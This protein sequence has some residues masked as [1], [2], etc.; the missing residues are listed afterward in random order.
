MKELMRSPKGKAIMNSPKGKL[1]K[2][3]LKNF[4]TPQHLNHYR[5][6]GISPG[7]LSP[8]DS[9][10]LSATP[11]KPN[12]KSA[13]KVSRRKLS[14][15]ASGKEDI[16]QYGKSSTKSRSSKP[17]QKF[18]EILP[19]GSYPMLNV[20]VPQDS[21]MVLAPLELASDWPSKERLKYARDFFKRTLEKAVIESR[22]KQEQLLEPKE[23]VKPK[24]E[25]KKK[26]V[27]FLDEDVK[28]PELKHALE[29]PSI[30][31]G[32]R[33]KRNR[34]PSIK[35]RESADLEKELTT[36]AAPFY[37][38]YE[39]EELE[40]D[41]DEDYGA[42]IWKSYVPFTGYKEAKKRRNSTDLF[43]GH[44]KRKKNLLLGVH[45]V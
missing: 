9:N 43:K 18:Q 37:P 3:R 8:S 19:K 15:V 21:E 17:V 31:T 29:K 45:I 40:D 23:E 12:A 16:V 10:I 28:Y 32:K 2:D 7:I 5:Q 22:I 39:D 13:L 38:D 30:S 4:D 35:L 41:L 44:N 34:F 1:I 36:S 11:S 20:F 42:D 33:S 27:K 25:K 6:T 26:S 24:K 14:L